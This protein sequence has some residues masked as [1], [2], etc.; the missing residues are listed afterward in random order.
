[1]PAQLVLASASPRR[2]ELLEKVGFA[3]KAMPAVV[4]EKSHIDEMPDTY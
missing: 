2:L 3:V 1:M 4:D